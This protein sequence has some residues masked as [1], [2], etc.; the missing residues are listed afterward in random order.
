MASGRDAGTFDCEV[1]DYHLINGDPNFYNY[2][3]FTI[4][5]WIKQHMYAVE[6][7]YAAFCEL[8]SRLRKQYARSNIPNLKLCGAMAA[9][10]I[11]KR[12]A[13]LKDPAG[14]VVYPPESEENHVKLFKRVDTAEGIAQK[15]KHLTSYLQALMKIP[16]IVLSDVLLYFLDEESVHGETITEHADEAADSKEIDIILA[17]LEMTTKTVRADRRQD[18]SVPANSVVVWAFNSINHDIGFSIVH[19]NKEIFKYQRCDSHLKVIKGH[20]EMRSAGEVSFLWDN[21]YSRWRSKTVNSVIQVVSVADYEAA[22]SSAAQ[23][24]KDKALFVLQRNMVKTALTALSARILAARGNTIAATA[25]PV[26]PISPTRS[27]S[28]LRSESDNNIPAGKTGGSDAGDSS[29]QST[30]T[31]SSATAAAAAAVQNTNLSR[32]APTDTSE[33]SNL[34]DAV[35]EIAK[36]RNEKK[37]LSQALGESESALVTE[38]SVAAQYTQQY[39]ELAHKHSAQEEE[40]TELK[41]EFELFRENYFNEMEAKLAETLA[42]FNQ[43]AADSASAVGNDA[44]GGNAAENGHPT[45]AARTAEHGTVGPVSANGVSE[46]SHAGLFAGSRFAAQASGDAEE[47][48]SPDSSENTSAGSQGPDFAASEASFN[49]LLTLTGAELQS[50]PSATLVGYY[51]KLNEF[52]QQM[53]KRGYLTKDMETMLNKLKN[54]KKQLKAYAIQMKQSLDK[55]TTQ[56]IHIDQDRAQLMIQVKELR[57]LV[58]L[59]ETDRRGL[60]EHIS[61]LLQNDTAPVKNLTPERQN[62]GPISQVED[63]PG[64]FDGDV[65]VHANPPLARSHSTGSVDS[66]P[67]QTHTLHGRSGNRQNSSEGALSSLWPMLNSGL[68][69]ASAVMSSFDLTDD[70]TSSTPHAAPH[71]P[72]TASSRPQP[73]LTST[74]DVSDDEAPPSALAASTTLVISMEDLKQATA[75]QGPHPGMPGSTSRYPVD[76]TGSDCGY[77]VHG[78]GGEGEAGPD[79]SPLRRGSLQ[80]ADSTGSAGTNERPPPLQTSSSEDSGMPFTKVTEQL[81]GILPTWGQLNAFRSKSLI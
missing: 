1:V 34:S 65:R 23:M 62:S 79:G 26:A 75:L 8:D 7:S 6:R 66:G 55:L 32:F 40:L 68:A 14:V 76:D 60:R 46:Y 70:F 21:S 10:K 20:F 69:S 36:L 74:S 33:F 67:E 35:R 71:P 45:A 37:T 64:Q 18:V 50:L 72:A 57:D 44:S 16:E 78:D 81:Y 22:Q 53:V 51:V 48:S 56:Y 41:A 9:I 19:K 77:S 12:N 4:K 63:H 25:I 58:A 5:V 47:A 80:R 29:T 2:H 27:T 49:Q 59:L 3:V 15:K 43:P 39:E 54:E 31:L 73:A 28:M 24:K 42:T 52:T 13:L 38:R 61:M 17:G 11:A 30:G